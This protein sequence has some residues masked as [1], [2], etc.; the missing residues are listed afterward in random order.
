MIVVIVKV[1]SSLGCN[2]TSLHLSFLFVNVSLWQKGRRV[3]SDIQPWAVIEIQ[4]MFLFTLF[5]KDYLELDWGLNTLKILVFAVQ[6]ILK[7]KR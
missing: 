1:I 7:N 5:Q 3:L 2:G 4:K 6:F